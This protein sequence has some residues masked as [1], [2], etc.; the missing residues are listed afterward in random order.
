MIVETLSRASEIAD[1]SHQA[2]DR[3]ASAFQVSK[4]IAY[5]AGG[6]MLIV[7]GIRQRGIA[8]TLL[9]VAG[10]DMLYHGIRGKG[11][12]HDAAFSLAGSKANGLPY[13]RGVMIKESVDVEKPAEQ[14]YRFW[15]QFDNLPT[16]MRN[17]QSVD[18]E[19]E[20]NSRWTVRGPAGTTVSW[21]AEVIADRKN[22]LIGW[23]A[24]PGSP[25][26]HAGSVRFKASKKGGPT[27]VAVTL[28][29]NPVAGKAGAKL[30][31]A[32][33]SDPA[34]QV[35]EDLQRFK[36]FAESVDLNIFDN[37]LHRR[38]SSTFAAR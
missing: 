5:G 34:V 28:Q 26:D 22:E 16:F 13:G 21:H 7:S 8:G 15:R 10:G 12:L 18:V 4:R 2:L 6:A 23:R 30:A 17:I 31:Q 19:D 29:Y 25:V 35:R 9:A 36:Q 33:G 32:L 20:S 14:L 27:T 37:L 24:V 11:H 3:A 38:N 1:R